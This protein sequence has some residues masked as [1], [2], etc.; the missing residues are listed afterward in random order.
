MDAIMAI[1]NQAGIYV[2]EDAAQGLMASYKGRA[3]GGIG[4][5]G[6]LSF[7]ATKN[8]TAGEGG[9][10]LVNDA[11]FA[12]LAE[13]IREKGTDRSRFLRGQVDK[14]TWQHIGSSYLPSELI[15]AFLWAQLKEA[16]HITQERIRVW[17]Y[18]HQSLERLETAG[19]LRRPGVPSECRHNGHIYYVVLTES[20][21]RPRLMDEL[22]AAGV[23]TAT[24]YVPLHESPAGKK[25]GH[26]HGSLP[27]TQ[28]T[29]EGIVRL[30]VWPGL[31]AEMVESVCSAMENVLL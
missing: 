17:D 13:V 27:N 2:V 8:V 10:L 20:S 12:R 23:Q 28:L 11:E 3:L 18:Y 30:P 29:A 14:Y 31:S 24:H 26:V 7:H 19:A 21:I 5:L 1:A 15:A 9:A 25:Y 6:A 4:H 22:K 16:E